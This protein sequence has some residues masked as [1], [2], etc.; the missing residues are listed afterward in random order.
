ML[1]KERIN[2]LP[3]LAIKAKI[4]RS[5]ETKEKKADRLEKAKIKQRQWRINNPFNLNIKLSKIKYKKEN[6]SKVLA[7][8]NK[9]RISKINRTPKWLSKDDYWMMEQAYELAILRKKMFGFD[10]H[11]DHIIPLQG[12]YVSGLHVPSNLQVIP[13]YENVSKANK[14]LPA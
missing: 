3:E 12:K 13:W 2:K 7:D 9:R 6:H 11:V 8:S 14:Y 4:S 1:K 5:N 10:W